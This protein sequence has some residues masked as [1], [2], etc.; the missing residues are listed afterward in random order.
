MIIKKV[1]KFIFIGFPNCIF[2]FL[3][4]KIMHVKYEANVSINGRIEVH[5]TGKICIGER[6]SINSGIYYNPIGFDNKTILYTGVDGKITIGYNVGIS[7]SAIVS[8]KEI[9]IG[10][11]VKIG[12]GCKIYDTDFHSLDY[13]YRNNVIDDKKHANCIPIRI[14]DG[15]FL[16]AG[17]IVLKGV[18]IGA[19]SV[20]GA[21][22]VV[23]KSI[24][25]DEIWA[26][27]PARFI[28]K[29]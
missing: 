24:P 2:N 20:I 5:N 25:E 18:T 27:N 21:G 28:R 26:G 12:G 10:N 15:V 13:R 19:N 14:G 22:S 23:T 29:I 9:I 11:N 3:N 7:N 17:V 1:L 8:M 4:F 16:G 6:T